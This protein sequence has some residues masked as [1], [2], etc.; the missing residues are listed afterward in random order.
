MRQ[1]LFSGLKGRRFEHWDVVYITDITGGLPLEKT[2]MG[3][4]LFVR[5]IPNS[6]PPR[7][8]LC[9]ELKIYYFSIFSISI[10]FIL[11]IITKQ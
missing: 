4:L 7:P 2:S 6:N 10:I 8:L 1:E 9:I 11:F 5:S 3:C